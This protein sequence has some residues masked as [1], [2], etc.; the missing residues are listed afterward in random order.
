MKQWTIRRH[1]KLVIIED[2]YIEHYI[3]HVLSRL[4]PMITCLLSLKYNSNLTFVAGIKRFRSDHIYLQPHMYLLL[5]LWVSSI[6]LLYVSIRERLTNNKVLHSLLLLIGW[7][8]T[9]IFPSFIFLVSVEDIIQCGLYEI[10]V[11]I[12]RQLRNHSERQNFSV[13]LYLDLLI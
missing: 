12:N 8:I 7:N 11:Q 3:E 5:V 1:I 4:I 2:I 10:K 9:N 13:F 6:I